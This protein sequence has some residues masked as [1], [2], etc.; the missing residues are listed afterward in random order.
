MSVDGQPEKEAGMQRRLSNSSAIIAALAA[1]GLSSAVFAQQ[2][3][4]TYRATRTTATTKTTKTTRRAT[5][6]QRIKV[7]KNEVRTAPGEV[8]LPPRSDT[9]VT[10]P[11][12]ITRVDTAVAV[13]DTTTP[14]TMVTPV[15]TTTVITTPLVRARPIRLGS[16]YIGIGGGASIPSGDIYN[17]YN[18]GWNVTVPMGWES[19]SLPFGLRLDLAYDRLMARS[20]FRNNGQTSTIVTSGPGGYSSGS[21][22]APTTTG[23]GS[24]GTPSGTTSGTTSGTSG[25]YVGHANVAASDAQLW[26]AMLDGKLR[27]AFGSGGRSSLYAVGGGGVHYFRNYG[28]TLLQ[29][30][31]AAEQQLHDSTASAYGATASGYNALTRFGLNAGAGMEWGV[32]PASLFLEGRYVTVLTRNRSTNYWPVI[33]GVTWR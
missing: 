30:N 11:D 31:P 20:T 25:G 22:T 1:I 15:D 19:T 2:P 10:V 18:P 3:D 32:G 27:M 24:Y 17:G 16:F 8:A 14:V 4:T 6:A 9:V 26:S 33:L 5:S 29:T 21:T 23:S 28:G 13:V 7:T 12:T